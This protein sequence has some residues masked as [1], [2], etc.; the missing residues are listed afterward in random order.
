[1][2]QTDFPSKQLQ[3]NFRKAKRLADSTKKAFIETASS[4]RQMGKALRDSGIDIKNFNSHQAKLGKNLNV[5]KRR[6][7]VL[8][9]NQNAKDA[10]L[11]NR[12]NYRSQMVDAVALGGVLYSVVKPAVDF[13]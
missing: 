6:Q 3:N 13:E 4:T 2:L 1:M 10:N 9:N 11:S 5:L 8:Q 12:T 7:S